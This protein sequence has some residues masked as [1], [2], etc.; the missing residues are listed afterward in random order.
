MEFFKRLLGARRPQQE[1]V[2]GDRMVV[3]RSSTP[4][5]AGSHDPGVLD[6][7]LAENKKRMAEAEASAPVA[8]ANPMSPTPEPEG[9]GQNSGWL[10]I[11]GEKPAAAPTRSQGV[12]YQAYATSD[13]GRAAAKVDNTQRAGAGQHHSAAQAAARAKDTMERNAARPSAPS[14]GRSL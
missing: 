11:D 12:P 3:A 7:V 2:A 13:E 9:P 5:S 6:R 10:E 14:A 4:A 8:P 1:V